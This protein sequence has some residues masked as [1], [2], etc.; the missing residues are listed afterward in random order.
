MQLATA[1]GRLAALVCAAISALCSTSALAGR[2]LVTEDAGV[3]EAGHCEIETWAARSRNTGQDAGDSGW[4]VPSCGLPL[5]LASQVGVL[6]ATE[7]SGDERATLAGLT[8]KTALRPLTDDSAG[9]AVAWSYTGARSSGAGWATYEAALIGVLSV[10]LRPDWL[11]HSNL[12]WTYRHA[13]RSGALFWAL[14]TERTGL[15]VVDLMAETFGSGR[16]S[17]W[18]NAGLRWWVLPERLS[19]NGSAGIKPA[20]GRE[21]LYTVGAKLQF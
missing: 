8:G 3:I 20:G 15:G 7:R 4:L 10:P 9:L 12:G 18:F 14:A 19:F 2:P 1:R 5:P 16:E 13:E 21:T 17:P 11:I 6:L